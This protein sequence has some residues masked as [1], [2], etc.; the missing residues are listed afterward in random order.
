MNATKTTRAHET[1]IEIE[2]PVEDVW[3]ALTEPEEIARWFAPK[4]SVEPGAGGWVLA[5]WGPGLVWKTAIEVWEPSRH[6]CLTETRD[7]VMS[8]SPVQESLEPSRLVQDYFLEGRGGT[9]VLRLVHSGFGASAEWDREFEGTRGG[10]KACFLRM[11]Y[12]LERHKG[13][14]VHNRIVT[15]FAEGLSREEVLRRVR[16][17]M[18]EPMEVLLEEDM[19]VSG[20]LPARNGSILTAS[21]QEAPGGAVAYMEMVIF[22]GSGVEA[23]A[24]AELWRWR[25]EESLC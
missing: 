16:G 5:D 25:L 13:E 24:Y 19:H 23:D 17:Q 8:T 2:A 12:G 15:H 9:T 14:A 7:K 22:G 18:M 6:L 21:I 20:L 11:K 1:V 10:W 3:K 4:M